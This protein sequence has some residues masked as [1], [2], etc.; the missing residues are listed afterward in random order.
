MVLVMIYS[1]L[2]WKAKVTAKWLGFCFV[3]GMF[4]DVSA[5]ILAILTEFC[6][7]FVQ[8]FQENSGMVPYIRAKQFYYISFQIH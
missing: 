2:I 6:R 1:S 7:V 3:F 5:Q 8:P 4:A